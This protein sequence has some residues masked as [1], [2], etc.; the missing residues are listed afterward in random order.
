MI[1]RGAGAI[2][3]D[4]FSFKHD[5]DLIERMNSSKLFQ[6][7]VVL[8]IITLECFCFAAVYMSVILNCCVDYTLFDREHDHVDRQLNTGVHYHLTRIG[9]II[10]QDI[11][12]FSFLVM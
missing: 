9:V 6:N 4:N 2:P 7:L 12:Y 11:E 1:I 10:T 8:G 5:L 3:F